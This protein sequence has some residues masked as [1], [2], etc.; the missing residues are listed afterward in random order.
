MELTKNIFFNTDK[1]VENSN[2]KIS[3]TGKFFQ[4]NSEKVF[5][6][7]G[8][9][10]NWNNVNEIEKTIS[11]YSMKDGIYVDDNKRR[12]LERIIIEILPDLNDFTR[13]EIKLNESKE[14]IREKM[15]SIFLMGE[16]KSKYT[17]LMMGAELEEKTNKDKK[18]K[19]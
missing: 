6:H 9:G 13:N 16:E 19:I 7:Y 1:L 18:M 10:Q 12:K 14:I 11:C 5:L 8:F 15:S 4:D 3:Y 2:V 17:F